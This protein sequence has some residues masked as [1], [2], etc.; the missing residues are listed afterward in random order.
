MVSQL[1]SWRVKMQSAL[2]TRAVP[3]VFA[4]REVKITGAV[5]SGMF[6]TGCE[7]GRF[8]GPRRPC[9]PEYACLMSPCRLKICVA[10]KSGVV[11]QGGH[12][13][14]KICLQG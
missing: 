3:S 10:L 8:N 11:R 6:G 5:G 1:R 14:S 4:A 12:M 9:W 7:S 13:Y 2:S